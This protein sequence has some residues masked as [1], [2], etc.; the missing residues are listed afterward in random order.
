[1]VLFTPLEMLQVTLTPK[2]FSW[3]KLEE[4]GLN[5]F[6]ISVASKTTYDI[7][8]ETDEQHFFNHRERSK[9]LQNDIKYELY[10]RFET[11]QKS[12]FSPSKSSNPSASG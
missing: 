1:M 10:I 12:E 9:T 5:Q 2:I 11:G 3:E 6:E 7:F 8:T 4:M